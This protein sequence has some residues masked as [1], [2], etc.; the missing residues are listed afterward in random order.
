M[1]GLRPLHVGLSGENPLRRRG[2]ATARFSGRG[3]RGRPPAQDAGARLAGERPFAPYPAGGQGRGLRPTDA[4]PDHRRGPD[5]IRK[6]LYNPLFSDKGPEPGYRN[7][8]EALHLERGNVF[9]AAHHAAAPEN[10]ELREAVLYFPGCG[11]S[12]LSRSIGLSA[13]GLLLRTGVAVIL[14]ESHL[15]CGYPLLS[16]GADGQ[17]A[18]NM[19]KNRERLSE[20]LHK[21][22]QQGFRV[23]HIVTACGSCRRGDRAP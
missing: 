23:T 14:P 8:Y 2:P 16:S 7:L 17:F 20:C 4:E 12:L 11:G 13:L 6:R 10:S 5:P 21:A 9:L 18:E 22:T 3:R 1:H 15:C 19:A